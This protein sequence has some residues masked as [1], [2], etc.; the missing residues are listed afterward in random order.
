MAPILHQSVRKICHRGLTRRFASRLVPV[1]G[2]LRWNP[3]LRPPAIVFAGPYR[4]GCRTHRFCEVDR[5]T[6]IVTGSSTL[7]NSLSLWLGSHAQ[8]S[9]RPA[10]FHSTHTLFTCAVP[11]LRWEK[12]ASKRKWASSYIHASATPTNL[13]SVISDH[14]KRP[15]SQRFSRYRQKTDP[16]MLFSQNHEK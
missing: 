11:T 8:A 9:P 2:V 6:V 10:P 14:S 16:T 5:P 13:P 15:I 7:H 4:T 1:P 12:N 3:G